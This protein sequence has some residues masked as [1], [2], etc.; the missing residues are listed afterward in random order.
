MPRHVAP[1]RRSKAIATTPARVARWP[2]V[3]LELLISVSLIT[4]AGLMT[5]TKPLDGMASF[6]DVSATLQT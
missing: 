4:T 2:N 1:V 5:C 3:V 6:K